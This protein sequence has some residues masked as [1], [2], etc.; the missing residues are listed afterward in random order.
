MRLAFSPGEARGE[1]YRPR[2]AG[3]ALACPAGQFRLQHEARLTAAHH[4]E[5][6]LGEKFAVEQS[7]ML[8]AAGIVDIEAAAQRIEIVLRAGELAPRDVERVDRARHR[9]PNAPDPLQLGIDEAHV[10]GSVVDDEGVVRDE[11]E[12]GVRHLREFRL[13]REKL[14]GEAVNAE[15]AFGHVALGIDIGVEELSRRDVIEKFETADFDQP[16]TIL[17]ADA[18][19]FGIEHDLAH[20]FPVS[21][22]TRFPPKAV[23]SI[24]AYSA[25][26]W[27]E[28]SSPI[29]PPG[30]QA[31]SQR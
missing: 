11:F 23:M 29:N 22:L 5:I 30:F 31:T 28:P 21:P 4:L 3:H 20:V 27:N 19:G 14:C 16:V 24:V 9:Q 25:E 17:R 10:E 7:A 6:D 26:K 15:G 13:V 2:G 18:R 8:G 12:K 1:G